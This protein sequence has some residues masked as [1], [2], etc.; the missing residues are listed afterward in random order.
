MGHIVGHAAAKHGR[1][2]VGV[3]VLGVEVVVV[4]VP[5]DGGGLGAQQIGHI[6]AKH[7]EAE[8]RAVLEKGRWGSVSHVSKHWHVHTHTFL[9]ELS[10][11]S[12]GCCP[13]AAMLPNHG[14]GE[15][16]WGGTF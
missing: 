11:K 2:E 5:E 3:E 8:H 16:T 13:K 14:T 7:G 6:G 15:G 4:R 12:M 1:G 10:R 9:Y